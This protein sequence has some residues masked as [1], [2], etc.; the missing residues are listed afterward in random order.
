MGVSWCLT[1]GFGSIVP[2]FY[3]IYFAVLLVHRSERDDKLC[4]EKY[5]DDWN[6]YKKMVPY[7][8]VPGII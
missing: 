7:R 5:G 8:F 4:Q 3:A 1:A 6:T 2:Y